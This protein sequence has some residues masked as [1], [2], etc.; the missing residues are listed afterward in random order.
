MDVSK[1]QDQNFSSTIDWQQIFTGMPGSNFTLHKIQWVH[2]VKKDGPF[3]EYLIGVWRYVDWFGG[4]SLS[5]KSSVLVVETWSCLIWWQRHGSMQLI[6][7]HVWAVIGRDNIFSYIIYDLYKL[8]LHAEII[9]IYLW[10]WCVYN[11]LFLKMT[12][13][14][15][16]GV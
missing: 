5:G 10:G 7:S 4:V 11:I 16:M 14:P 9:W 12:H 6:T 2:K 1:L 15:V 3:K 8:C 13:N